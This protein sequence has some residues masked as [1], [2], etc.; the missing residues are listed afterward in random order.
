M[1]VYGT[2]W[3]DEGQVGGVEPL[4]QQTGSHGYLVAG[5]AAVPYLPIP[6][7]PGEDDGHELVRGIAGLAARHLFW[8]PLPGP[9]CV[10]PHRPAPG[11]RA[12]T[13][14]HKHISPGNRR[15]P[16]DFGPGPPPPRP[17]AFPPRG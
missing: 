9:P 4:G 5:P 16:R 15:S 7:V 10:R 14:V 1:C 12:G 17:P 2:A 13:R 6:E 8:P 11:I 3:G